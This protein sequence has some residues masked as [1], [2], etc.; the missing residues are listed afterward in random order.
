MSGVLIINEKILSYALSISC[1]VNASIK[2]FYVSAPHISTSL[3][4]IVKKEYIS[5]N[6]NNENIAS[7]CISVCK[8]DPVTDYCY[9][10]GRTTEDKKLWK[11]PNTSDEWKKSNLELTRSR[12]NG[13]Q[14]EAWD[15][16]YAYKKET[17]MSLIKKKF[18]EQK[19]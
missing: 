10:C 11:D 6:M 1:G 2:F 12:L 9:G 17:G 15:K 13:W 5:F 19:K 18:L 7:P 4:N 16:S 14:Q 8:S 3:L